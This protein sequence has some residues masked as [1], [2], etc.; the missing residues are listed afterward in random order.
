MTKDPMSVPP[1]FLALPDLACRSLGGSVVAANDEF[2]A[3]RE[4]LISPGPPQFA[5]D[6]FG[7]KGKVYDGWE[8]RRRR[9][10]GHD[11]AI[12]R[13]AAPGTVKGVVVDTAWFTGNFPPQV[14]VEGTSLDGYPSLHELE[15]CDWTPLVRK[16]PV[17]GDSANLFAVDDDRCFTHIRLSIFP[18]GGVAR[19]RV[20]GTARPDPRLLTGTIDLAGATQGGVVVAC[21]NT[22]YSSPSQLLLPGRATNMGDGWE[23]A[24]RREGEKDFVAVQLGARG[25]IRRIE[26]DTS[27]FIGNAPGWARVLGADVPP[28]HPVPE[29]D[30]AWRE[31]VPKTKIQPD[32][33]HILH[34]RGLEPATHVRLEI[35]PDGGLSRLRVLG[36]VDADDL[37]RYALEW[38]NALPE[39]HSLSAGSSSDRSDCVRELLGHR[40]L[41]LPGNVPRN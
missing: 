3:E 39:G 29:L 26:V 9:E 12:V 40:P 35:F 23:T 34:I 2:F 36:E 19:L 17:R 1:D 33:R 14:S 6:A 32:T 5:R 16:S 10:P 7:H 38:I 13:L 37:E 8:T 24:R 21:S 18:D 41:S 31:I 20:H 4:N 22:H 30:V 25:L 11:Y 27:F 15:H 28:G